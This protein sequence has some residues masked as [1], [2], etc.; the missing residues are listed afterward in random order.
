MSGEL[1]MMVIGISRAHFHSPAR[2]RIIIKLPADMVE[3]DITHGALR[4]S[5]YGTR[6]AAAHFASKVME[7]LAKMEFIIGVY[8][9]CVARHSSRNLRLAY[10][11]N[12][13]CILG[14]PVEL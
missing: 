10:N 1:R 12:D 5:V 2:R 7:V 6:D 13:V 3:G 9:P 11:G 8:S 14:A 4:K